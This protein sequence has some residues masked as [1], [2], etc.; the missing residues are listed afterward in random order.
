MLAQHDAEFTTGQ[1][2]RIV[3]RASEDGLR[4]AL[5]RLAKQGIVLSDRVGNAYASG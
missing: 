2:R 4:K 3:A 1:P 5:Q